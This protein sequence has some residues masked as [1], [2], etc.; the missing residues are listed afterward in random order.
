MGVLRCD[1][2]D[3]LEFVRA[4][5]AGSG[6]QNF[7][8]S[9]GVTDEFMR[10]TRTGGSQE[11]IDPVS[12]EVV[13]EIDAK[14]LFDEIAAE[15]WSTGDPG[16]LFLDQIEKDDEENMDQDRKEHRQ[17]SPPAEA[18]AVLR[19]PLEGVGPGAL[20]AVICLDCHGAVCWE[21]G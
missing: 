9:V 13:G 16:L 17:Q 10:R 14:E 12:G 19:L 5:S 21:R 6:L 18:V 4:K 8:I 20:P 2:P 15:A 11:L 1:H 3:V 7:N